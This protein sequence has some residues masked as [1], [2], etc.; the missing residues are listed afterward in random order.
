[1]ENKK[2]ELGERIR[3]RRKEMGMTQA[4]LAE[5][6]YITNKAVS[7][8]ETGEASPDIMLLPLLA[9]VLQT[10]TDHLL[11]CSESELPSPPPKEP[12]TSVGTKIKQFLY[13]VLTVILS[14]L[15]FSL[16]VTAFLSFDKSGFGSIADGTGEQIAM[17][18]FY[19]LLA[20]VCTYGILRCIR[21]LSAYSKEES[22]Y[23]IVCCHAKGYIHYSELAKEEKK[24]LTKEWQ[25]ENRIIFFV[26]AAILML[27]IASLVLLSLGM[28]PYDSILNILGHIGNI[29]CTFIS[30]TRRNR[31]YQS[32]NI[33]IGNRCP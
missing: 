33:V 23:L 16:F 15:S 29:I 26:Y 5:K 22:E 19:T 18:L 31:F 28:Y 14:F 1:M 11:G 30:I 10:T 24:A 6:L 12:K 20:L 2:I 27:F 4:Q 25:A 13:I 32:R 7:K 9:S 3:N 21:V 8:W 17:I